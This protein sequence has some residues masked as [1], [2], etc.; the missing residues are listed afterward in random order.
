MHKICKNL[1][2]HA[3]NMH[4]MQIFLTKPIYLRLKP[5]IDNL[6]HKVK[7][8]QFSLNII[9]NTKLVNNIN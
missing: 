8:H 3:Q 7:E 4:D 1:T 9:D 6:K 5:F 2:K